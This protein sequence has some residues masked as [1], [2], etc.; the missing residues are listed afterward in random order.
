MKLGIYE[1]E[2]F[3]AVYRESGMPVP[4]PSFTGPNK[5]RIVNG[6]FM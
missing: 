2:M 6:Y 4:C 5:K 3:I 1:V